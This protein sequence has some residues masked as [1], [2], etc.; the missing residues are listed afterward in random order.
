MLFSATRAGRLESRR[1]PALIKK[2][3]K[4]P[5]N[6]TQNKLFISQSFYI[7]PDL[8]WGTITDGWGGRGRFQVSGDTLEVIPGPAVTYCCLDRKG[9]KIHVEV[10]KNSENPLFKM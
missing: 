3:K 9:N 1:V 6:A 4:Q 5:K 7:G 10:H 2:K 8:R